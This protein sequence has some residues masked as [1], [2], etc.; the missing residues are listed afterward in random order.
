MG[1]VTIAEL[2]SWQPGKLDGVSDKLNTRRRSLVDLQDEID[3]TK[4]PSDWRS[5]A[6]NAART[7]HVKLRDDLNDMAAEIAKVVL[8]LD[9]A[10]TNIATAKTDLQ[11]QLD[12]ARTLKCTVD[13]QTGNVTGPSEEDDPDGEV[14][15]AQVN[16]IASAISDALTDAGNADADLATVMNAARTDTIDGGTGTLADADNLVVELAGVTRDEEFYKETLGSAAPRS[17]STGST[18]TTATCRLP[19][20]LPSTPPPSSTSPTRSRTTSRTPTR[21]TAARSTS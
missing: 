9:V 6:G 4:P 5:D 15:Q 3:A 13:H 17:R 7:A 16:A 20:R 18:S 11:G 1:S 21:S 10:S 2:L 8:G 19:R 12:H 14:T